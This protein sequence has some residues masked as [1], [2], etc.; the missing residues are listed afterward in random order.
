[1]AESMTIIITMLAIRHKEEKRDAAV[2][3]FAAMQ[4]A[5][6]LPLVVAETRG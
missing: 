3:F 5:P 1:M 4:F 2:W 6:D